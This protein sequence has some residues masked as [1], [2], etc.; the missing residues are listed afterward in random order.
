[1]ITTEREIMKEIFK[2]AWR[3]LHRNRRRTMATLLTISIGAIGLILFQG[4]I[5]GTVQTYSENM[6]RARLGHMKVYQ[7]NYYEKVYQKPWEHWI[8]PTPELEAKIQSIPNV[9]EIYPRLSFYSLL[10]KGD[11]QVAGLGEGVIAEKERLFFTDLNFIEGS[12]IQNTQQISL[13]IGLAK[14]LG[15][16]VGDTLTLL[17]QN[18][19]QQLSGADLVVSGIFHSGMKMFDDRAFRIHLKDA[20]SV[21]E[22]NRIEA[23]TIQAK[24]L[25]VAHAT[26]REL[27][28]Q[29][30]EQETVTYDVIDKVYFKNAL[31]FLNAQFD[32]V[33]IIILII[34]ALGIFSMI[35]VGLFERSGELGAL[36][37]NGETRLRIMQTLVLE[38]L[39]LGF[40][41]GLLGI[42]ISLGI[43]F[44]FLRSG[45]N[46]PPSPGLT[47]QI[48]I[49]MNIEAGHLTH[50]LMLTCLVA[51]L[52]SIYP[53]YKLLNQ[54]IPELLRAT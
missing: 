31:D 43:D 39:F 32:F 54:K 14:S 28:Q 48:L 4:F 40:L 9:V 23:Y 41:G 2:L 18:T 51:T 33:R 25:Q 35:S 53:I 45:I 3:N 37:A 8:E 46:M 49:Y 34:V 52:S 13:G 38:N 27:N 7:K 29:L 24:N 42:I 1:M 10:M 20:Q 50:A 19:Y 21:L 26:A 17:T 36:R 22:T 15:A 47:R 11:T 6:I 12:E 16:K 44:Q 30:P 5:S